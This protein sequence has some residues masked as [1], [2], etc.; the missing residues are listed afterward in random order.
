MVHVV[1][2]FTPALLI[3][4]SVIIG[5]ASLE[6][7]PK[8]R[9]SSTSF[10]PDQL[11]L[12]E[13][14]AST[15]TDPVLVGAYSHVKDLATPKTEILRQE[16]V[17]ALL[18]NQQTTANANTFEDRVG[19]DVEFLSDELAA[20]DE[21]ADEEP[22]VDDSIIQRVFQR[23]TNSPIDETAESNPAVSRPDMMKEVINL[24]GVR[25]R[26]GGE[27]A[28]KG[29]D[30]SA[31]TGTVYSRALGVRLPRSSSE[32]FGSGIRV[33]KDELKVGDLVFFKTR[34]RRAPVSHVGIYVGENLF[35]HASTRHGVIISTLA[36]GYYNRTYVGARR[37]LTSE[38]SEARVR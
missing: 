10:A 33:K 12:A 31:F 8:F 7:L 32:Q 30:C 27:D 14:S 16:D 19:L 20:S 13:R 3:S 18:M 38:Y 28:T 25:Y 15:L 11:P 34:R 5:C 6:P 22:P 21:F 24:L 9:A 1:R 2:F 17:H 26:F 35:A 37:I 36:D 4:L 29:I 23:A